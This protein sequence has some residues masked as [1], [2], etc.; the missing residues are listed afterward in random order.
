MTIALTESKLHIP[1]HDV[2][3]LFYT[4]TADSFK[5]PLFKAIRT[6]VVDSNIRHML[7]IQIYFLIV[8]FSQTYGYNFYILNTFIFFK[9]WFSSGFQVH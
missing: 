9:Y 6:L 3:T 2:N 8:N 4:R 7:T 1:L 5:L